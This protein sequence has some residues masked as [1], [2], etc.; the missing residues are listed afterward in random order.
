M[1]LLAPAV[2]FAW[3]QLSAVL[4]Q[5]LTLVVVVVVRLLMLPLLPFS[6]CLSPFLALG[7]NL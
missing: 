4:E 6:Y 7:V 3:D 2:A 5:N 1:T